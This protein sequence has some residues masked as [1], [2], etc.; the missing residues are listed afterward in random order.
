MKITDQL[1]KQAQAEG[2]AGVGWLKLFIKEE[3]KAPKP[4][5]KHTLK[6]LDEKEVDDKDFSGNPIK[7]IEYLLE[8]NEVKVRY[9]KEKYNDNGEFHYFNV[10]MAQV[11]IGQ[12]F[13][14]EGGFSKGKNHINF[15]WPAEQT[16][17]DNSPVDIPVFEEGQEPPKMVPTENGLKSLDEINGDL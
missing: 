5:G 13:I 2:K 16:P 8:E 1:Y 3:G 14:L 7:K 12:T 4:T 9:R 17:V 15:L 11:K 6:L 10:K